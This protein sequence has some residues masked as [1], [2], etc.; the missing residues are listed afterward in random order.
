M[1][2]I[3]RGGWGC[4]RRDVLVITIWIWHVWGG[5]AGFV[6]GLGGDIITVYNGLYHDVRLIQLLFIS[7]L[8]S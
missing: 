6:R 5:V 2:V 8:G 1:G 3:S 7:R 4:V